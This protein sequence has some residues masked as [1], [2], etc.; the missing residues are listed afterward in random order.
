MRLD[1]FLNQTL[2]DL[3]DCLFWFIQIKIT[4]QKGFKLKDINQKILLKILM[5]SSFRTFITNQ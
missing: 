2:Q 3:A 5:S 1:I 4:I